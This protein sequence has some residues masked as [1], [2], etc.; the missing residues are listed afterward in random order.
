MDAETRERRRSQRYPMT[1]PL[2]IVRVSQDQ[3]D[4][5]GRTRNLSAKGAYFVVSESL[6]RGTA[7][8]F[9]VT[10]QQ[11]LATAGRVRLHCRGHVVRLDKLDGKD[12][13]GVAATIDR[14]E[15]VRQVVN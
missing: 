9:L 8:E 10:L 7:I 1:L 15:F 4:L 6:E 13:L 3:A 2:Q 14:Y 11:E 5:E 12:R